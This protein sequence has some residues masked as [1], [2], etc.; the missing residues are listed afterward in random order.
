MLKRLKPIPKI[1]LPNLKELTEEY[2]LA[3]KVLS[4]STL[5]KGYTDCI[6]AG[7]STPEKDLIPF[8]S[9]IK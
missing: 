7:E 1:K 6:S 3:G 2:P 4:I 9:L 8:L 5:N